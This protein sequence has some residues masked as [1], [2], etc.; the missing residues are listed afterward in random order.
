[1]K[2]TLVSLAMGLSVV[3]CASTPKMMS[4]VMPEVVLDDYQVQKTASLWNQEPQS[5]FG[6]R[7]AR[8]VGDILTIIVSVNDTAQMNNSLSRSRNNSE[9]FSMNALF[10]APE[11]ANGV[12]PG[13]ARVDPGV[14]VTRGTAADGDGSI[15]RQERIT[16][17]LAAQVVDKL[18]N[19]HLVVEGVQRIQVNHETRN[20]HLR[21][22]VRPDDISRNNTITHEKVAAAD[23]A[24]TGQGQIAQSVA[25]RKG[26]RFLDFIIPF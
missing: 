4:P 15:S 16:L 2:Y 11:W 10:G 20:L 14:Q 8:N 19:G 21:G 1:M 3:G 23:I 12:L 5:L 6:N 17:Q 9:D 7:R 18:P 22:I 26:S 24:Y 25:P 13:G